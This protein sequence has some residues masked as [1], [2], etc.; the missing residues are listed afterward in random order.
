MET[1]L[2]SSPSSLRDLE[3]LGSNESSV[4]TLDLASFD[5][6]LSEVDEEMDMLPK[7]LYGHGSDSS[8]EKGL[9]VGD[10]DDEKDDDA[11]RSEF[12][13]SEATLSELEFEDLEQSR[14]QE[15][16]ERES[17]LPQSL[18]DLAAIKQFPALEPHAMQLEAFEKVIRSTHMDDEVLIFVVSERLRILSEELGSVFDQL[19]IFLRSIGDISIEAGGEEE[20]LK[21]QLIDVAGHY[22]Q[23]CEL[24]RNAISKTLEARAEFKL[25]NFV[26]IFVGTWNIGNEAPV[27]SQFQHWLPENGDDNDVFV[28]GLQEC[29]YEL[30]AEMKNRVS[31][32]RVEKKQNKAYFKKADVVHHAK[33][34]TGVVAEN[35]LAGGKLSNIK[36]YIKLKVENNL[37]KTITSSVGKHFVTLILDQIG[38]EYVL[39]RDAELAQMRLFVFTKKMHLHAVS[40]VQ[41][42][43][44]ATGIGGIA[45]NK[46]AVAVSLRIYGLRLGWISCHLAAHKKTKHLKARNSNLSDIFR[47]CDKILASRGYNLT[48]EMDHLFLLGDLNYRIDLRYLSEQTMAELAEKNYTIFS[49]CMRSFPSSVPGVEDEEDSDTEF[50]SGND[51]EDLVEKA[52]LEGAQSGTRP[53]VMNKVVKHCDA[54]PNE[55]NLVSQLIFDQKWEVLMEA[56]QLGNEMKLLRCLTSFQEGKIAFEPTFKVLRD[57]AIPVYVFQRCPSYCD[58]VLWHSIPGRRSKIKQLELKCCPL[59]TSSDHK[60]VVSTFAIEMKQQVFGE[61]FDRNLQANEEEL[62][63]E[64]PR[65]NEFVASGGLQIRIGN[66]RV[67]DLV[68]RDYDG[69]ASPLVVFCSPNIFHPEEIGYNPRRGAAQTPVMKHRL[70]A[71]WMDEDVPLIA[72]PPEFSK[73]LSL[74]ACHIVIAVWDADH[75]AREHSLGQANL[76]LAP[77]VDQY[78]E[79]ARSNSSLPYDRIVTNPKEFALPILSHGKQHGSVH[80]T[81][82]L[83]GSAWVPGSTNNGKATP[84]TLGRKQRGIQSCCSLS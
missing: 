67:K 24:L 13:D 12:A 62:C 57:K 58:R 53:Q 35:N 7:R 42:C 80:G 81:V 37:K 47:A 9:V 55:W 40:S 66:L 44:E 28:I 11:K 65:M 8:L 2:S 75:V 83:L 84:R 49:Q 79:I 19:G 48:S 10:G 29:E 36:T 76:G 6:A 68:S 1:G 69:Q 51:F 18:L 5:R 74:R 22:R 4:M 71:K 50:K 30:T 16:E 26:K 32:N 72:C 38:D 56:D 60:P 23:E 39:V 20:S 46:G 31:A 52:D 15:E 34:N 63:E 64:L 3:K 14:F 77:I 25:R 70:S 78:E 54:T 61:A 73:A 21:T 43:S 33:L 27:P 41:Y 17:T 45:A 59:V 82:Q